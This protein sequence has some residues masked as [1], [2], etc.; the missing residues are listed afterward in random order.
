[1]DRTEALAK[2]K[3]QAV[4]VLAVDESQ[5]TMEAAF[6]DDLDADSSTSSSSSWLSKKS[7]TSKWVKTN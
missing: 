7:S 6:G 4:D 2:F 5:L 3:E 1:M